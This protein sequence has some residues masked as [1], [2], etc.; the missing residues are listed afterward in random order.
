ME[1]GHSTVDRVVETLQLQEEQTVGPERLVAAGTIADT[2]RRNWHTLH[3]LHKDLGR[4]CNTD[5]SQLWD[6]RHQGR[7]PVF[8]GVLEK[9]G[10]ALNHSLARSLRSLRTPDFGL[11]LALGP[12]AA[13][14]HRPD[15]SSAGEDSP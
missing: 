8:L 6:F 4:H 5:Y 11:A 14:S 1:E 12:R 15:R 9:L 2:L 3:R 7:R 13:H 10:F